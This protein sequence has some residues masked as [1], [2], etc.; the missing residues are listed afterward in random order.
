MQFFIWH[1][2]DGLKE[3]SRNALIRTLACLDYFSV[4]EL[5]R[6]LLAPWHRIVESYGRGFNPQTFF[7][8]LAGNII[9]RVLGA[10]V[11]ALVIAVGIL[12][13]LLA[14]CFGIF[15]ILLWLTLLLLI[16]L[17]LVWGVV[18]LLLL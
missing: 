12:I 17:L 18:V 16:P 3:V 4:R 5:S 2:R 10:V 13:T 6:T 14:A 9:S 1:Y 11:R 15:A 7:F 8:T